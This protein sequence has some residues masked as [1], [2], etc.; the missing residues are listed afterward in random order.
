MLSKTCFAYAILSG[1]ALRAVLSG[2]SQ[3]ENRRSTSPLMLTV[4]ENLSAAA[5]NATMSDDLP[6]K[7]QPSLG[8]GTQQESNR[9]SSPF[10]HDLPIESTQVL[11]CN[12]HSYGT[13]LNRGSCHDAWVNLGR[14][15]D[16]VR[17]GPRVSAQSAPYRL[18]Y[19]WSSDDGACV[20]EIISVKPS[21]SDVAS[22]LDISRAAE[23]VLDK[24]VDDPA[25]PAIGG[26]IKNIGNQG[27]L[28][29]VVRK[30]TPHVACGTYFPTVGFPLP[31]Q[32]TLSRLP[33]S[34]IA[35]IFG[36]R[37]EPG[38]QWTVPWSYTATGSICTA[39]VNIS[40]PAE[41]ET[42]KWVDIWAAAV[43]VDAICIKKGR[44]GAARYLGE[45][46]SG[47]VTLTRKDDNAPQSPSLAVVDQ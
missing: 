10:G 26:W 12:S 37:R 31:C 44:S 21:D 47:W 22:R 23:R 46:M 14:T 15:P 28:A 25:L 6:T 2:S 18:P 9:S 13:D 7:T 34:T 8:N 39:T 4:P 43:A 27:R 1:H 45:T 41:K 40:E 3:V 20:I 30:Y 36:H 11:R 17:W 29:V 32:V 33:V 38:T 24:C 35:M 42:I 16:T 5:T 19:R